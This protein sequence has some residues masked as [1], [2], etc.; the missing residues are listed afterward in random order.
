M[1]VCHGNLLFDL[2]CA[3]DGGA[4]GAKSITSEVIGL[5]SS[6][7]LSCRDDGFGPARSAITCANGASGGA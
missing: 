4:R 5:A 6:P 7:G 2:R 1:R 3:Q